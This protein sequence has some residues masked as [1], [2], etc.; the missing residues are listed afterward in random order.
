MI[1]KG[2]VPLWSST[3]PTLELST[4]DEPIR[5][6]RVRF[7]A[8]PF[9]RAADEIDYSDYCGEFLLS[10]LPPNSTITVSGVARQ[11]WASV[12]GAQP[13]PASQLLYGTGGKPM[14]WPELSCNL[15]YL[16][17]VDVPPTEDFENLTVRLSINR[18]E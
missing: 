14:E 9:S 8:N 15:D 10:Y 3:I 17:T 16:M 18:A 5:Q 1:P 11:A 13:V 6:L 12:N 2:D 7:H 4:G